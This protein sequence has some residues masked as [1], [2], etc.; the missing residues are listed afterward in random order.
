M[1]NAC[2]SSVQYHSPRAVY[3]LYLGL[4]LA[5]DSADRFL[6]V[7]W[8][9]CTSHMQVVG[10]LVKVLEGE[11]FPCDLVL[12]ASSRDEGTCYITT[13]NLDGEDALK[14][15]HSPKTTQHL[16]REI[17][18]S[19]KLSIDHGMPNAKL[20]SFEGRL[21]QSFDTASVVARDN[22]TKC[23][24]PCPACATSFTDVVCAGS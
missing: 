2:D 13:V 6:S 21:I 16:A 5:L 22:Q 17:P 4:Y 11:E 19:L 8:R 3:Y 10:D 14:L 18:S 12:V 23:T 24:W 1:V 20:D 15:R 9:L 7:P